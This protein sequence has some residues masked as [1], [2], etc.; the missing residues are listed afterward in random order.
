MHVLNVES[1]MQIADRYAPW[2]VTSDVGNLVLQALQS[3][4]MGVYRDLPGQEGISHY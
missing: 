4:K 3:R 1:H 2:K